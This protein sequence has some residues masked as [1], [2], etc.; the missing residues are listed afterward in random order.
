MNDNNSHWYLCVVNFQKSCI[1][2]FD[3][4]PSASSTDS[5]KKAV[6]TVVHVNF[7]LSFI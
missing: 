7:Y 6:Q 5:R 3:S 2:I 4:S 1:H